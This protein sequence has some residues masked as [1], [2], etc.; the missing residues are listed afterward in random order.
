MNAE[1]GIHIYNAQILSRTAGLT[2][3]HMMPQEVRVHPNIVLTSPILWSGEF[4]SESD[5]AQ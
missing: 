4:A 2:V 1:P 5:W 3:S